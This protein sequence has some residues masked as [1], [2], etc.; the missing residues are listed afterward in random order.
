MLFG[1]DKYR[2]L[3]VPLHQQE[4]CDHLIG[5]KK[6]ARTIKAQHIKRGGGGGQQVGPLRE[7]LTPLKKQ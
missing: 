2:S 1:N 6:C 7:G 5:N 3:H 4:Y